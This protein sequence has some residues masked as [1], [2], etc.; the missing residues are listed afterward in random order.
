MLVVEGVGLCRNKKATNK[1]SRKRDVTTPLTPGFTPRR[2]KINLFDSRRT[3]AEWKR[4]EQ[5]DVKH[6]NE[7]GKLR[8]QNPKGVWVHP[9]KETGSGIIKTD[10]VFWKKKTVL[11]TK[12]AMNN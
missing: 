10:L 3:R 9:N 5:S 6:E 11:I 4:E 2:G 7:A 1:S 12:S 8:R